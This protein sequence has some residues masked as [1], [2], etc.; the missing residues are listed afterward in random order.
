MDLQQSLFPAADK[1]D[2]QHNGHR[3]TITRVRVSMELADDGEEHG[4]QDHSVEEGQTA[5]LLN[6]MQLCPHPNPSHIACLRDRWFTAHDSA[7]RS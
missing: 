6:R 5:Q 1:R 2:T 4:M 3:A 7:S